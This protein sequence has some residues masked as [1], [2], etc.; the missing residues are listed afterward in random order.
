VAARQHITA[1]VSKRDTP[2]FLPEAATTFRR[3]I[4]MVALMSMLIGNYEQS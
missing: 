2:P 3:H 1:F 4:D